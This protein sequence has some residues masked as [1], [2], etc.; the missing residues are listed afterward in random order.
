MEI[1]V[2]ARCGESYSVYVNGKLICDGLADAVESG[3]TLTE[4]IRS[5]RAD[6]ALR[7]MVGSLVTASEHCGDAPAEKMT[8]EKRRDAFARGL[9][10]GLAGKTVPHGF[11]GVPDVEPEDST[12]Y[13]YGYEGGEALRRAYKMA[14]LLDGPSG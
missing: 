14:S 8:Q 5:A 10:D 13:R 2:T 6:G 3:K 1:Q 9:R 12:P 7:R 4:E 11:P